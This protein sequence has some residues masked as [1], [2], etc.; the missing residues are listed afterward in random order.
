MGLGV[1]Q[2]PHWALSSISTSHYDVTQHAIS[3][4]TAWAG[5]INCYFPAVTLTVSAVTLFVRQIPALW[6]ILYFLSSSCTHRQAL[7]VFHLSVT[8]K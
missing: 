5:A 2:Q 1:L 8:P 7:L 4:C 6:H 3:L